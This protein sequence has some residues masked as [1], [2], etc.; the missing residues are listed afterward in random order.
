VLLYMVWLFDCSPAFS[1]L[2]LADCSSTSANSL[3]IELYVI[4]HNVLMFMHRPK[5]CV[6]SWNLPMS[7]KAT[8]ILTLMS[9]FF[10]PWK[11]SVLLH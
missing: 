4:Q 6:A 9:N 11:F 8:I 1:I 10:P 5:F 2:L 7:R 3:L